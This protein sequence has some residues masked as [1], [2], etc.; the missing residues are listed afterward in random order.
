MGNSMDTV[1]ALS[2]KI[3]SLDFQSIKRKLVDREHGEGWAVAKA[4][5][6]EQVYRRFL[7]LVLIHPDS[8]LVPQKDVDTFWH[9][10]ILDTR[11]Y[12]AD[13]E[14]VFGGYLHH[15]PY[16]GMRGER[17]RRQLERAAAETARL[18]RLSFGTTEPSWEGSAGDP[19][20][21]C[22]SCSG[23]DIGRSPV[24]WPGAKVLPRRDFI[25]LSC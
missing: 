23:R 25:P 8:N 17:D 2:P 13:C 24:S 14:T 15:F 18:Y 11:K 21:V 5:L 22:G 19:G 3:Q 12:V 10:H 20:A 9:Y 7:H 16:F 6:V 1:E 4:D